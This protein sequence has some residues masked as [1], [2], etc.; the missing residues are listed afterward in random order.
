VNLTQKEG[1]EVITA[2][3]G[4]EWLKTWM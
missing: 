2:A 1:S 4:A 3:I